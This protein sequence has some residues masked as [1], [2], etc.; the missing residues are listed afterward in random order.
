MSPPKQ[1]HFLYDSLPLGWQLFKAL[2]TNKTYLNWPFHES[3]VI[4][5]NFFYYVFCYLRYEIGKVYCS[6]SVLFTEFYSFRSITRESLSLHYIYRN[7]YATVKRDLESVSRS[8][9]Q[10]EFV[11]CLLALCRLHCL[12]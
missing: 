8:P 9:G 11:N 12:S 5:P 10:S 4:I 3:Q 7:L 1:T 6:Q 2:Q